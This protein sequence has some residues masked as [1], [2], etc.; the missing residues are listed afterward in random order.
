MGEIV[1]VSVTFPVNPLR[2]ARLTVRVALLP[3]AIVRLVV[4]AESV[5]SVTWRV[6]ITVSCSEP[7]TPVTVT[8]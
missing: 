5:K 3:W 6:R 4:E 1:A 2:L 7:L 8:V